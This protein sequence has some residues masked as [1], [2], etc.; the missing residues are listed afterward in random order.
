MTLT[1][2]SDALKRLEIFETVHVALIQLGI[3]GNFF[4]VFW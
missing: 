4:I 3:H 2:I 1:I